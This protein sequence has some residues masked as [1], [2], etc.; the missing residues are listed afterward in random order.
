MDLLIAQKL[1][2]PYPDE[3]IKQLV[4]AAIDEKQKKVDIANKDLSTL[5]DQS[6]TGNYYVPS[7]SPSNYA[8]VD[9]AVALVSILGDVLLG[10]RSA[11]NNM[12]KQVDT[13]ERATNQPSKMGGSV[14]AQVKVLNRLF[15][16]ANKHI[17][18][19]FGE[20]GRS[21]HNMS[22][23]VDNPS[24]QQGT[25]TS[26]LLND[27]MWLAGKSF[28][29]MKYLGTT[30]VKMGIQWS[31]ARID[32]LVDTL[33]KMTGED[34]ILNTPIDKLTPELNKKVLVIS[35]ILK[36]MSDNPITKQAVTEVA[37]AI[38]TLLIDV[39]KETRPEI[40]KVADKGVELI[41]DV[42]GKF[43]TGATG[44]I[45]SVIQAFFAEIPW[46]G[47]FIVLFFAIG[48]GFNMFIR[49]FRAFIERSGKMVESGAE[50]IQKT[51]QTVA[52]GSKEVTDK[53]ADLIK[54]VTSAPPSGLRGGNPLHNKI[55]RGG[56][57][58]AQTLKIFNSTLP[59]L[60]YPR[61]SKPIRVN[62]TKKMRKYISA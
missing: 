11:V 58:L 45:V 17:D 56:K 41:E 5:K 34:D 25:N 52:S 40:N 35:S 51:K 4:K 62:R 54:A 44:T 3:Y 30:A 46:I 9:V 36:N 16:E 59:L 31:G 29:A 10:I 61:N 48:K 1:N 7:E 15:H 55:Q 27:G 23:G 53:S 22:G 26:S 42:S 33:L 2:A 32:N 14:K 20:T 60:R 12:E 39:M 18:K 37:K 13:I 49:T 24:S 57:R 19:I 47:G 28:D 38:A 50:A 6:V 21:S 8:V 43:V